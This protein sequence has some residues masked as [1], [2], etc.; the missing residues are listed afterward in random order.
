MK[1]VFKDGSAVTVAVVPGRGKRF[2]GQIAC[3][4]VVKTHD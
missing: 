4:Q 3:K 1:R 2:P